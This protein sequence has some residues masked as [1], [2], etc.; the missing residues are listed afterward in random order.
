MCDNRRSEATRIGAHNARPAHPRNGKLARVFWLRL[1]RP[2]KVQAPA[3]K[4]DGRSGGQ[5]Q[6]ARWLCRDGGYPATAGAIWLWVGMQVAIRWIE[7]DALLAH[8]DDAW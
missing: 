8:A 6:S 7:Y 2:E 5:H 1:F 4:V 3:T